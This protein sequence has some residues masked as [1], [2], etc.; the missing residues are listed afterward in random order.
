M[1][2]LTK[3]HANKILYWC[4]SNYGLSK[5]NKTFPDVEYKKHDYYTEGCMAYYDE[6]DNIIFIS[7][8]DN[9]TLEELVNSII[10]EYIHYKQN[11]KEYQILSK[12]LSD[13]DNPLEIEANEIA[14]RDTKKCI[15]E[16][17]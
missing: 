14:E 4:L 5:Y 8:D 15:K 1:T 10:H 9:D 16:V 6:I 3:R 7:K 17:F 11:M 13:F 2:K 12:T